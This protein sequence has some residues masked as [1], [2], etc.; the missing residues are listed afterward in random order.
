MKKYVALI[1]STI[2]NENLKT[3]LHICSFCYLFVK[4]GSKD[5]EIFKERQSIEILKF[6]C[7]IINMKD[8][9]MNT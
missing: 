2:S 3:L 8:Y 9:Q 4:P 1:L 5:E 6:L 7:L